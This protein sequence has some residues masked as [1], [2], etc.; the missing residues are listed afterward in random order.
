MDYDVLETEKGFDIE[1]KT[2]YNI[3]EL[4]YS[5][6][7]AKE[8]CNKLNQGYGFSGWTPSFFTCKFD[9]KGC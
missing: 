9:K 5:S 6:R 1:E 4:G 8:L 2:T 7:K 3:L